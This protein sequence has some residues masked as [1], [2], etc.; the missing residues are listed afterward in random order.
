MPE[1]KP[2]DFFHTPLDI[3]VASAALAS[4]LGLSIRQWDARRKAEIDAA[5]K[6]ALQKR[7]A[8]LAWMAEELRLACNSNAGL[9]RRMLE[10][11]ETRAVSD[12]GK[13]SIAAALLMVMEESEDGAGSPGTGK[14]FPGGSHT[15]GE[16][17]FAQN[18]AEAMGWA[19]S[20]GISANRAAA[21][22]LERA[23]KAPNV[24]IASLREML[25]IHFSR[26]PKDYERVLRLLLNLSQNELEQPAVVEQAVK[27]EV[28]KIG[29]RMFAEKMLEK[30]RKL[31]G[32][33]LDEM[34]YFHDKKSG[35]FV[36]CP[37]CHS[38][39]SLFSTITRL[40]Q[41]AER[42]KQE[43]PGKSGG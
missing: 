43:K 32:G 19:R 35:V 5:V 23:R 7:K 12:Y 33:K 6:L 14:S 20:D 38:P 31:K 13:G 30:L 18:E 17:A 10:N 37:K 41:A 34:L 8:E 2:P 4:M 3:R 16:P 21:L 36:V 25:S 26:N 42:E 1:F 29:R 40:M 39:A 15:L 9:M 11:F 24:R 27:Q 28:A 22:M